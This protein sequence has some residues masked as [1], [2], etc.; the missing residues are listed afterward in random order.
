ME[1][2]QL[3]SLSRQ[4]A[5]QRQMDVIANNLANINTTG[6]KSESLLFEDYLSP[7]GEDESFT[8]SRDQDLHFTQ[9]WS[10][11]HDLA[12]GPIEQTGN[13]LDVALQGNGFLVVQTPAGE[14]Y[15]R[16]GSLQVDPSGTLVDVNGNP[17]LTDA[18]PMTF[19]LTE[20]D[21]SIGAN[22]A[23]ATNEGPKGSLRLVEF[24][25]ARALA[26]TGDNLFSGT[27]AVAATGTRVVQGSIE[28]SNVSGVTEIAG[29][30]RVQRAY[31]SIA[32]MMQ[33]QDEVLRG[34]IQR[35]GSLN[36]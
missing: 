29:M 22:G 18:G 34:A 27:G 12:A 35:L 15:T 28:R 21:I 26:R 8:A 19:S 9:D 31:A 24:P 3:I 10:T 14:R 25:D 30:I 20:T 13:T 7:T 5:I 36:A 11:I 4:M 16:A 17:V 32:S 23:I 2:A 6:F 1:N 33:R